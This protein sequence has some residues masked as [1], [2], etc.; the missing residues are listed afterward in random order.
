MNET[1]LAATI[2]RA[3][4]GAPANLS[5]TRLAGDGSDR[6]YWRARFDANGLAR[7]LVVM[8]LVGVKNVVASEEVTLYHPEGGEL[9][10]LN[11][12]RTL[13]RAGVPV[14]R[15][16][17]D[18]SAAGLVLLEDIGDELLLSAAQDESRRENL[19]ARAIDILAAMHARAT[20]DADPDSMAFRQAFEYPLLMWELRHF[21]EYGIE[22]RPGHA[23]TLSDAGRAAIDAAY[24]GIARH[25]ASLA[26]VFTHRDYHARN[27]LVRGDDLVVI[28]FQDALLGPRVYDLASLL[29]DSYIDLGDDLIDRLIA[30][31]G[32]R[33]EELGAPAFD[34]VAFRRDF[35]IQSVQRNLKAAG[36]FVF[37]DRVKGNPKFLADIP[38]TLAYVKRNLAR[39]AELA[40]LAAALAPHVPE[41]S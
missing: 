17:A 28:D 1:F 33:A 12:H 2:E 10:F 22:R 11:I 24:D 38:R 8:D 23:R 26:R 35:D 27:L 39:H 37:F 13:T 32:D 18:A 41:L 5:V 21:T 4:G 15:I 9:P 7:S 34:R 16:V 25:L 3:L 31:Y 14:P 19:Y 6:R 40:P 30:R 29:R 36:R 20:P